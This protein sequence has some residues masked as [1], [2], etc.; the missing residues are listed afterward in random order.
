MMDL[1]IPEPASFFW[2]AAA[3]SVLA[4]VLLFV[5]HRGVVTTLGICGALALAWHAF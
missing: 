1:L 3:L 4:V 5:M 2:P